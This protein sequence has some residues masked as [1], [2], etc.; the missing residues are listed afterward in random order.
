M[1]EIKIAQIIELGSAILIFIAALLPFIRTLM[2]NFYDSDDRP[3]FLTNV[4]S[5][6]S[7]LFYMIGFVLW[8]NE[9]SYKW[10]VAIFFVGWLLQVRSYALENKN[11]K[12]AILTLIISSVALS[13][14]IQFSFIND[15]INNQRS[16]L[17]LMKNMDM[18]K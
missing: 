10:Q 16:I 6:L 2:L 3:Q 7:T 13:M 4:F 12:G 8:Y 17:E 11:L 18:Q 5:G 14:L 1:E 15:V 9:G